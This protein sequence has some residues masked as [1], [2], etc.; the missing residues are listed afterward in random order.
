MTGVRRFTV[1]PERI[2]GD[3]VAFD[4]AETR[5]MQAVLRLVP[6]DLV[7]AADGRGR[8]FTVRLEALGE[9]ATGTI[10]DVATTRREASLAITLLQGIPKGDKMEMIVRAVTEL[11]V[12]RVLPAIA[13]RTV[14]RLE[15]SR[16]RERARRWQRVAKEAAKQCGRAVIPDVAVPRPLT[17][18]LEPTSGEADVRLCLWEGEAPP[19]GPVLDALPTPPAIA[20]V[21]VGPEGGLAGEEVQ[22]AKARGWTPVSLGPRILRSETAAQTVVAI[23]QFRFGDLGRAAGRE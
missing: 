11:G 10:L 20:F 14:V 5:H 18:W 21:L 7:I 13:Q 8:D 23:L 9:Q 19:I 17:E 6:G 3:R 12:V 15:S 4:R 22:A 1:A 2:T 16:W